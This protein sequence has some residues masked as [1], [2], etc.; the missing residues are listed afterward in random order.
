MNSAPVTTPDDNAVPGQPAGAALAA[1]LKLAR[2]M[3]A[4]ALQLAALETR[5][6]VGGVVQALLLMLAATVG[7]LMAAIFAIVALAFALHSLGLPWAVALLI[8][9]ATIAVLCYVAVRVAGRLAYRLT[10]PQTRQALSSEQEP[11]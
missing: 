11:Q 10:L 8:V 2:T 5:R 7:G 1:E 6:A 9:A 4:D 3:F